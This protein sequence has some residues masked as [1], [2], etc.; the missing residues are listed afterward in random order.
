MTQPTYQIAIVGCGAGIAELHLKALAQL[1][2]QARIVGMCDV[3]RERGEA[4]AAQANAPFFADHRA[5]IEATQPDIVAICTP[6]PFHAPTSIPP[7]KFTWAKA[8]PLP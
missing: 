7:P 4:R 2:A 3:S 1:S 6:H 8:P 5:M